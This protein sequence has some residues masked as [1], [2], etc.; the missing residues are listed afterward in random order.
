MGCRDRFPHCRGGAAYQLGI[1]GT[2]HLAKDDEVPETANGFGL[3]H[4][5]DGELYD[6]VALGEYTVE[7]LKYMGVT[8]MLKKLIGVQQGLGVF[9]GSAFQTFPQFC[10]R[11]T[12]G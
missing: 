12:G 11:I 9:D 3:L 4:R 1:D 7:H 10:P 8:Q 2:Q 6:F 5:V